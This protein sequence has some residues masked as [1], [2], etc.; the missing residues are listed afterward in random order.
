[1][2]RLFP[3]TPA[4]AAGAIMLGMASSA[5][6][7]E[8][9][10]CSDASDQVQVGFLLGGLDFSQ[11]SGTYLRVGEETWSDSPAAH[12][13]KPLALGDYFFDWKL[14]DAI[15]T[16]ENH[17]TVLAHLQVILATD[18]SFDAKGGVLTVP[19]K[20]AWVVECVGP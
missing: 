17:E 11:T 13:G 20:G 1:M 19:G 10:D 2:P 14:L 18:E 5:G 9:M 8:W 15:L 16:D 12:P 4:V 7:T 6:A 3:L